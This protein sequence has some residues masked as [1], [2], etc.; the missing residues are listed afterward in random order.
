VQE[1]LKG[2]RFQV[3]KVAGTENPA[4]VATKGLGEADATRLL[5]AVGGMAVTRARRVRWADAEEDR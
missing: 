4:D 1:A 3:R 5:E 2:G